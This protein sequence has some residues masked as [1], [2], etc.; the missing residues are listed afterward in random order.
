MNLADTH[1]HTDI[2]VTTSGACE[3]IKT[4]SNKSAKSVKSTVNVS[5]VVPL[6]VSKVVPL[7]LSKVSTQNV[8]NLRDPLNVQMSYAKCENN[9]HSIDIIK[10][11]LFMKLCT[12]M[13]HPSG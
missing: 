13:H 4:S 2:H 11:L 8:S 12:H 9:T 5:K 1:F 6:N 7:N 10:S 3:N